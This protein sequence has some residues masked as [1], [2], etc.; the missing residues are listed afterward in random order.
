MTFNLFFQ[1]TG[2]QHKSIQMEPGDV[3]FVLGAN[4]SGK[5]SLMQKFYQDSRPHNR[6]ISAHRQTWFTSNTL[7]LTP[8]GKRT[9]E[10]N[11]ANTDHGWQ[12]RYMDNYAAARANITVFELIDAQNVRARSIAAAVD[13]GDIEQACSKSAEEAPLKAI[14]TLLRQSNIPIE[15]DVIE[16]EQIV[17]RKNGGTPYSVAE[18]SDGE[19]NALLIAG[20]VLTA[21]PGTLLIIDEPERHLHRAIISPLLSQLFAKRRDCA[22]VIATHDIDLPLDNEK[23]RVLLVRSA[24]YAGQTVQSWQADLLLEGAALDEDIR[25][26]VIGSRRKIMFVEGT[27]DSLDKPLYSL[28]FPMVSVVPKQ[29]C[30][31]VEQA[32]CGLRATDSLTWIH[33]WGVVD[34]DGQSRER[35]A[36]LAGG[37]IFAIPFYSV[38][39]I[40]YHPWVLARVAKRICQITSADPIAS[41]NAAIDAGM[42][43]VSQRLDN[44]VT[45]AATKAARDALLSALPTVPTVTSGAVISVN[46]DTKAL[47]ADKVAQLRALLEARDWEAIVTSCPVRESGALEPMCKAVG[48]PGRRDYEAAVRTMLMDDPE[49]LAF[50]RNMFAGAYEAISAVAA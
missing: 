16:N 46:I 17:A 34:G 47:V 35:I 2:G 21:K 4:G 7:D 41:T 27:E 29:S 32:V 33:A 18:L 40:Y 12:S 15:I 14:N 11:I 45:K 1:E 10:Q 13:A 37:G 30:K 38:E 28:I 6:R 19:R 31:A 9:T 3:L 48:F 42:D 49:A 8:A 25:R 39:S 36:Q 44:M 43:R 26:D 24:V 22:F 50:V 20:D 23:A 5:S